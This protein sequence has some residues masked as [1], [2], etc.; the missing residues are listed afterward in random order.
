MKTFFL[1]KHYDITILNDVLHHIPYKQQLGVLK[2]ALRVAEKVLIC[3][4]PNTK[5]AKFADKINN[6]GKKM[7]IPFCMRSKKGWEYLFKNFKIKSFTVKAELLHPV[8][9]HIFCLEIENGK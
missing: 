2:E 1:G 4:V 6:F 9:N 8:R 7:D 5:F 3:E